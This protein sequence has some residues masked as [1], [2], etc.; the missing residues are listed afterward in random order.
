MLGQDYLGEG[1]LELLYA[2]HIACHARHQDE[3]LALAVIRIYDCLQRRVGNRRE[4]IILWPHK[5]DGPKYRSLYVPDA[6][7]HDVAMQ[8][9]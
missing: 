2:V 5:P 8:T 6:R 3:Q 7:H 1:V 9:E 4:G